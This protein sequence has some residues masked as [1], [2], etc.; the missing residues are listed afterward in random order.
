MRP[1]ISLALA[2]VLVCGGVGIASAQVYT[3]A[4][5]GRAVDQSG[6]VLP[7]VT[8]TIE[9]DVLLQTQSAVT[10]ETGAYRFAD[11]PIGRYSV[12]FEL[13]GFTTLVISDVVVSAGSTVTVNGNL[14]LAEVTEVVTVTSE[15]PVV[16]VRN[17]GLPTS[18]NRDRLEN[19]PTAR[20]PWVI[21]EQTP[22][23]VMDRQNVGGN[24]SGQQ[25]N[26]STRG[27][28]REQNVWNYDGVNITDMAA[29]GASP[30][31]YDFGAFEEINITTGGQD[32]TMQTSGTALNFVVKQGTN[33][34]RGQGSWYFTN[35]DLQSNNIDDAL[36][37]QGAGAGA[38]I[39]DI[40]DYGFDIGGPILTDRLWVWGDYGVQDISV[41]TVGFLVP[42]CTDGNDPACL[43]PDPTRLENYNFKVNLK[44]SEN[45]SFN[46]LYARNEKTRD[47]RGA[48][49]TRP[50]E[51][52][53]RQGGPTDIYKFEDQH[54]FSPN[55]L[56]TGR[57]AYV[58]GGFRLDYQEPNL[59]DVQ[60]NV[61]LSDFSFSKSYLD[62]QTDRPQYIFNLD[63]NYFLSDALGGDHEFKFGY[64][65][66]H[67]SIDSFT[68]Y[69]GDVWGVFD[70]GAPA[71]AW[72]YRP[73]AVAYQGEF[74][75]LHIQDVF[76][77]EDL[78]VKLALRY[79][80]Q[81]GKNSASQIQANTVIPSRMP[82]IDFPGTEAINAWNTFSPRVG[83]TYD[84]SGDGKTVIK[85]SYGLY[86][87]LL[88]LGSYVAFNNTAGV[89]EMDL[90][91]NDANGDR[92]VQENELD[93][94]DV[95]FTSNFDPSNPASLVS[96]DIR[97]PDFSPP[98]THELIGGIERQ[99]GLDFAIRG[100][101]IFKRFTNQVWNEWPY[102]GSSG[103]DG[104]HGL[105]NPI[106]QDG[107][108][109]PSSA[110]EPVPVDYEGQQ[111]TYYQ[112]TDGFSQ[113][114]E[115]LMNRPDYYRQ[116]QGIEFGMTKR[117]SDRFM[118]NMSYTYGSATEDI[119]PAGTQDPTN[120]ATGQRL[121]GQV[122]DYSSGS[123]KTRYF[124]NSRW[125]WRL[126]GVYQFPA[127]L[128]LAGSVNGRQ[129]FP[130]IE[131][132]RTSPR[133]G[134][135][136]RG[137]IM[138]APP[139]DTRLDPLWV[140]NLRAE[141]TFTF[142]RARMS[143]MVDMFNLFNEATALKREQRQNLSN[144]NNIQSILS[145]RVFRI[146]LRLTF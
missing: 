39:K 6:G 53:W 32:A 81:S 73:G 54:I 27:T 12:Q 77:K 84:L 21:V 15:S 124:L 138:L 28:P 109:I 33:Q 14:A 111:L 11:L 19:I 98:R 66:K 93:F 132:Y 137:E 22:G 20:D 115:I 71:E 69:G 92:L 47:T 110:F 61:E 136:G 67:A 4:I 51:T 35:S 99:L 79:D 102:S 143:A 96:P 87:D 10:S 133:A 65:Y 36:R 44:A 119:G 50:L 8:V 3:G 1:F 42:G 7:G 59:R 108:F 101:Y 49:D 121:D 34:W 29:S 117:M 17:T 83:V 128:S 141:Y 55:F 125:V 37:E 46:F 86:Y 89:A 24:E 122:A 38:P 57:F 85:G 76:T 88:L 72:L 23:I 82:A 130:F 64:Q 13:S 114:G 145:P 52:T 113:T 97:D 58:S 134:G 105:D 112:L 94:T 68:T 26:W 139:G 126:D 118:L 135:I 30:M 100:N 142:E 16:D 104:M 131:S 107:A 144:A 56:M 60:A 70:E 116:F 129:G 78:T 75:G 25:S 5:I 74:H 95:L 41:G 106:H 2:A 43:Q 31:Y 123:G 140:T 9:G 91:W 103:T 63:G 62:Y 45:N 127:G 146:G 40:D 18:F 120:I 80:Y 90:P 48:S